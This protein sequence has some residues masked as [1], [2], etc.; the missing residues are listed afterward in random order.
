[1]IKTAVARE[2]HHSVMDEESIALIHNDIQYQVDAGFCKVF[3]WQRIQQLQPWNLK[4]SPIT[5]IPQ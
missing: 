2:P 5:M 3:T 4:I 1:M